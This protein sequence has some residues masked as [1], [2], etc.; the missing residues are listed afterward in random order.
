LRIRIIRKEKYENALFSANL[1]ID[2][3]PP[4]KA[5]TDLKI[6]QWNAGGMSNAVQ[7]NKGYKP[8]NMYGK[9]IKYK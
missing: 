8:A 5:H 7:Y 6:L 2:V 9:F 4:T 3:E 1:R